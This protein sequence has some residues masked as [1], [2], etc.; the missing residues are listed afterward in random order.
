MPNVCKAHPLLVRLRAVGR[1]SHGRHSD[2][3]SQRNR[4]LALQLL[5]LKGE[6]L[7][8]QKVFW[9]SPNSSAKDV[10]HSLAAFDPACSSK[11]CQGP[12]QSFKDSAHSWA[13]SQLGNGQLFPLTVLDGVAEMEEMDKFCYHGETSFAGLRRFIPYGDNATASNIGVSQLGARVRDPAA[14]PQC[15]FWRAAQ[16]S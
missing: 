16:Y 2:S 3:V 1:A 13:A 7:F 6:N 14:R 5:H 10:S 15:K 9:N 8:L 11:A 4:Q 12:C